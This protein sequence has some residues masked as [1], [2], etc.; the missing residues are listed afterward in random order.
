MYNRYKQSYYKKNELK[1]QIENNSNNYLKSL[2]KVE[3]KMVH[4]E[5]LEPS[6]R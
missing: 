1:G 2:N 5:G 4:P 3:K 6:T